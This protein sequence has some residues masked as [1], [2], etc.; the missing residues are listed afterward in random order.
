[1]NNCNIRKFGTEL[2]VRNR[3]EPNTFRIRTESDVF[4]KNGNRNRTEILKNHFRTSLAKTT[5]CRLW[6]GRG[7][8]RRAATADEAVTLRT[9]LVIANGMDTTKLPNRMW[10]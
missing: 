8:V 3:T 9:D 2:S 5:P 7:E 6:P 4:F 10:W 1:M